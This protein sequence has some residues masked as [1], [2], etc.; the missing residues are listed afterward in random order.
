MGHLD[1]IHRTFDQQKRLVK[2]RERIQAQKREKEAKKLKLREER[3]IQMEKQEKETEEEIS[4]QRGAEIERSEKA[5]KRAK[6]RVPYTGKWERRK[7]RWD[8]RQLKFK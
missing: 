8:A 7:A 1:F 2:Q 6:S 3:N 5:I 4:E